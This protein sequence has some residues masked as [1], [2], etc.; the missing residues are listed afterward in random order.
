MTVKELIE[1][2]KKAPENAPVWLVVNGSAEP[3]AIAC[4]DADHD[5]RILSFTELEGVEEVL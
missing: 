3:A 2:L 5:V 4:I 1:K